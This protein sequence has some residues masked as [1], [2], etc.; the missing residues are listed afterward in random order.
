[1]RKTL[2]FIQATATA[3]FRLFSLQRGFLCFVL[4][5]PWP[6][7]LTISRVTHRSPQAFLERRLCSAL[8]P[9]GHISKA[10]LTESLCHAGLGPEAGSVPQ[11]ALTQGHFCSQKALVS[12]R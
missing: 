1:M 6:A 12:V 3:S 10:G 7:D 4:A 5:F 11:A 8:A 9:A 2:P